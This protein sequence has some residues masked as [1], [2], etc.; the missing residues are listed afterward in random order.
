[1]KSLMSPS[2]RQSGWIPMEKSLRMACFRNHTG[3]ARVDLAVA[4]VS[5]GSPIMKFNP[6]GMPA[7]LHFFAVA[8]ACSGVIPFDDSLRSSTLPDSIPN[9]NDAQPADAV[10]DRIPRVHPWMNGVYLV[11]ALAEVRSAPQEP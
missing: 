8:K 4:F 7:F 3:K 11:S 10:E 6:I 9:C 5:F 2:W 1:M